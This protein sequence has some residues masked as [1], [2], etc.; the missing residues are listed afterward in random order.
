MKPVGMT[1]LGR[2][3]QDENDDHT[4]SR[5]LAK[6]FLQPLISSKKYCEDILEWLNGYER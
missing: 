2:T 4:T 5:G 3:S 1:T 6:T